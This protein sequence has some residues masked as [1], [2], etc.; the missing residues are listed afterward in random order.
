MSFSI[1]TNKDYGNGGIFTGIEQTGRDDD[2]SGLNGLTGVTTTVDNGITYYDIGDLSIFVMGVVSHNPEEE[3]IIS[4]R[5]WDGSSGNQ[6]PIYLKFVQSGKA[7]AGQQYTTYNTSAVTRNSDLEWVINVG[8]SH[9]DRWRENDVVNLRLTRQYGTGLHNNGVMDNKSFWVKAVDTTNNTITVADTNRDEYLEGWSDLKDLDPDLTRTSTTFQARRAPCY[10][11]GAEITANGRTRTSDGTG[12]FITGSTNSTYQENG[13]G[14]SIQ[15]NCGLYTLGGTIASSRPFQMSGVLNMKDTT[16]LNLKAGGTTTRGLGQGHTDNVTI[17]G[18]IEL[19]SIKLWTVDMNLI[20][21]SLV[22]L[23]SDYYREFVLRDFESSNNTAVMEIGHFKTDEYN[24]KDWIIINSANGSNVRT[25]WRGDASSQS[26]R[27][28][29]VIQKEVSFN[30]TNQSGTAIQGAGVYMTDNPSDYARNVTFA[31]GTNASDTPNPTL[32]IGT[33]GTNNTTYNYQQTLTYDK[34]TDANGDTGLFNVTTATQIFDY[35]SNDSSAA[36]D[37]T[38]NKPFLTTWREDDGTTNGRSPQYSDWDTDAFGGFYKVDRRSIDNTDADKFEFKIYS[39]EYLLAQTTQTLRGV[40]SLD[41]SWT[42]ITDSLITQTNKTTVDDYTEIDSAARL[43]DR[44]KSYLVDNYAGETSTIVDRSGTTIDLG[45]YNLV[46]NPSTASGDAFAFDGTTITIKADT[47]TGSL[48]TTGDITVNT[49]ST[50]LGTIIDSSN[51]NGLSNRTFTISNILGGT[52]V[53]IYNETRS[54]VLRTLIASGL[55]TNGTIIG[56]G[57]SDFDTLAQAAGYTPDSMADLNY[58]LPSGWTLTTTGIGDDPRVAISGIYEEGSD[59][60]GDF[61]SGDSVRLR[62]TCA[63]STGAFLPFVTT[64]LT[65]DAGFSARISQV[66][67]TIYND[68]GIN[69]AASNY[70]TNSLTITPDYTNMQIDVTDSDNP[71]TVTVQQIYAKYAYLITTEDG[72]EHFFGAITAENTSNYRINTNVVDLKIQN[73]SSSDMILTGA[74]LYRSDNTTV[75]AKGYLNNNEAN[76]LAGTLSHDTGEFL[77]Y[78]QP[79]V[80]SALV[81][82]NV[83]TTA[84]TDVIKKNTNLIP[85]LL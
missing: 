84:D 29:T 68:N 14:L 78:I 74:R 35:D 26:Q 71:G 65:N 30:L 72:I 11:Y 8:S 22:E 63:A 76:G 13:A 45:S 42:L 58:V 18:G 64:V 16:L 69:G 56:D 21:G 2:L 73:I 23:V 57:S 31:D 33:R 12:I 70:D 47:F 7:G 28:I 15:P 37:W 36:D 41:V 54:A 59:P 82:K 62:A 80:E 38:F 85:G 32:S 83:T 10:K 6:Q 67:D 49:G 25:M 51:P 55:T 46:L 77:Q 4:H 50:V 5:D 39:Y 44:A 48:T 40:G 66:A 3:V 79:Q 1:V 19:A 27:G 43:Y 81:A 24:H 34:Q 17:N 60:D 9:I 52:T 61:D 53:Q 75:I 20:D